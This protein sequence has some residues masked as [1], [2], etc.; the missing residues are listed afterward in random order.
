MVSSSVAQA[1]AKKKFNMPSMQYCSLFCVSLTWIHLTTSSEPQTVVKIVLIQI[2]FPITKVFTIH[3]SFVCHYPPV[4]KKIF[5]D[6][7]N[8]T[9]SLR[10][11]RSQ[12]AA[13]SHLVHWL[14]YQTIQGE[15]GTT[16]TSLQLFWLR[17]LAVRFDIISLENMVIDK[18][19]EFLAGDNWSV[20]YYS[21]LK[22]AFHPVTNHPWHAARKMLVD[23]LAATRDMAKFDECISATI[24]TGALQEV[25]QALKKYHLEGL[26]PGLRP[27]SDYH[28]PVPAAKK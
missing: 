8:E 10:L 19:H 27:A 5:E 16:L 28:V 25:V 24:G 9:H 23:V 3:K 4:F 12:I 1:A 11:G 26:E 17:N 13:F 2:E 21:I 14:Y 20:N 7:L 22:S 18:L 6:P 15:D